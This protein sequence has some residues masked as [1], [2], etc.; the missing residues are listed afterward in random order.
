MKAKHSLILLLCLCTALT[1]LP[2]TG[3]AAEPAEIWVGN[4]LLTDGQYTTDGLT[5]ASETPTDHYAHF[6]ANGVPTLTL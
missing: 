2:A 6:S 5:V 4:V 1:L 3:L